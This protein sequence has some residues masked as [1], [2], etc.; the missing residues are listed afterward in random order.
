MR[1]LQVEDRSSFANFLPFFI[2]WPFWILGCFGWHVLQQR[3]FC[4][5]IKSHKRTFVYFDYNTTVSVNIRYIEEVPFPAVTLCNINTFRLVKRD[6]EPFLLHYVTSTYL[7]WCC[8][9]ISFLSKRN[10]LLLNLYCLGPVTKKKILLS[11]VI[12]LWSVVQKKKRL[13]FVKISR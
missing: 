1:F 4:S 13:G 6:S 10:I 7:G 11:K 3:W 12:L 2:L 9:S 8:K 5:S